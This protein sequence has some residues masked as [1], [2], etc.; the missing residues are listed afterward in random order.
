MVFII[1]GELTLSAGLVELPANLAEVFWIVKWTLRGVVG[2]IGGMKVKRD[3]IQ[4]P[5]RNLSVSSR[6]ELLRDLLIDHPGNW[7]QDD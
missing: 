1:G 2:G 3:H 4:I 5:E 6:G 7:I